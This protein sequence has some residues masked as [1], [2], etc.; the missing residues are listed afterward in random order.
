[1]L[2]LLQGIRF[3]RTVSRHQW[4]AVP[5]VAPGFMKFKRYGVDHYIPGSDAGSIVEGSDGN[6]HDNEFYKT[7]TPRYI[8]VYEKMMEQLVVVNNEFAFNDKF[9]VWGLDLRVL[10]TNLLFREGEKMYMDDFLDEFVKNLCE[11]TGMTR[12]HYNAKDGHDLDNKKHL[13]NRNHYTSLLVQNKSHFLLVL[14]IYHI[15]RAL[16]D[17]LKSDMLRLYF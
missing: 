4:A 9:S 8:S 3:L 13:Y 12:E 7:D 16:P 6:K 15:L 14:K 1:M 5:R 11:W 2:M 10:R 17:Q